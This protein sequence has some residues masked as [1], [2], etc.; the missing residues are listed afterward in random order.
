MR[1]RSSVVRCIFLILSFF[2]VS[3]LALAEETHGRSG[4]STFLGQVLNFIILFGGLAYVLRK[5][6][7]EYL[8]RKSEEMAL[9]LQKSEDL[10]TESLQK[11]EQTKE[12]LNRLEDEVRRIKEEAEKEA[13]KERERIKFEAHQEAERLRKLAQ[14]EIDL[15]VRASLLELK[16][17]AI[18]LSVAL[19]EQKIKQKLNPELHRKIIHRAI[20]NLRT[21]YEASVDN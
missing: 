16:A 15:L 21:V 6:V 14:E 2:L 5:P 18:N 1:A 9:L 17:Y 12:R 8:R 19:S 11:L 20:D 4:L 3:G 7:N 10:K 13:L